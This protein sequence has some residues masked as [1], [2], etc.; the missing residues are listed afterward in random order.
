MLELFTD[1]H[2]WFTSQA[3][4]REFYYPNRYLGDVACAW[5]IGEIVGAPDADGRL[6]Q[7]TLDA[8][9]YW[10]TQGWGWGEHLSDTYSGL[11][12]DELSAL[13]LFT[14]HLPPDVRAKYKSLFDE[15][16]AQDDAYGDLPRVP[17]VRTYAFTEAPTRVRYR[18]TVRPLPASGGALPQPATPAMP[19]EV[20]GVFRHRPPMGATLHERGWHKLA[21]PPWAVGTEMV[22]P[23]HGGAVATAHLEHDVRLGTLSRYPLMGGVDEPKWGMSW[24]TAPVALLRREGDWAFLQWETREGDRVRAHPALDMFT[25][26]RDNA[27]SGND[28]VSAVGETFCLQRG[29]D[30]L[31]L[32]RMPVVASSWDRLTD[33]LR[34][35]DAHAT[36]ETSSGS[37]GT[38]RLTLRYPQGSIGV[39]CVPLS[40]GTR[41]QTSQTTNGAGATI[42]DWGVVVDD[43]SLANLDAV[44][45]LWGISTN[46]AIQAA[47]RVVRHVSPEDVGRAGGRAFE[48]HWE[49][50]K[51]SWHVRFNPDEAQPLVELQ[52]A[53]PAGPVVLSNEHLQQEAPEHTCAATR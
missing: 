1:L 51:T 4:E 50:P 53:S 9:E 20:G 22:V 43:D 17:A 48:F 13:L 10:A 24:Q 15:L 38:H 31:V 44:T 16:L 6:R 30:A 52:V 27:L 34:I 7:A 28:A 41:V 39:Q 14:K 3:L 19:P 32:R 33:R 8:A 2:V 12:L 46:G 18:D 23:C 40:P 21:P 36:P 35:V 11:C 49:W 29:G 26:Y 42:T 5:T 25:S 45:V 47:P 37:D